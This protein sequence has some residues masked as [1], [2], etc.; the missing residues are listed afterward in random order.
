MGA[1]PG[2]LKLWDAQHRV[3][4]K[5]VRWVAKG[6]SP[7]NA[8]RYDIGNRLSTQTYL[9][10]RLRRQG[11]ALK[12]M[13]KQRFGYRSGWLVHCLVKARRGKKGQERVLAFLSP[14]EEV[15]LITWHGEA[16]SWAQLE[17]AAQDVMQGAWVLNKP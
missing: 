16:H 15:Y 8:P 2:L 3:H 13:V 11:C 14:G 10:G 4:M 1:W 9:A 7:Y 12:K 17:S 5:L 6:G